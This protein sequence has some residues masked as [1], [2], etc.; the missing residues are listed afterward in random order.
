MERAG[1]VARREAPAHLRQQHRAGRNADDADRQLIDAIGVIDRRHRACG[2]QR[3]DDRIGEERDLEPRRANDGGSER[4]EEASHVRAPARAQRAPENARAP[5]VDD[6]QRELQRARGRDPPSGRVSRVR[7]QERKRERADHREIQEH[8][9]ESGGRE[10]PLRVERARQ[11]RDERDEREIRERHARERN[12][13]RELARLVFEAWG[14]QSD[15][16][17]RERPRER[18]ERELAHEQK[19]ADLREKA[20]RRRRATRLE[21]ARVGRH[22]SRVEGAF[23]EDRAEMIGQPERDIECVGERARA[24]RRAEHH[25]AHEPCRARHERQSRDGCELAVHVTCFGVDAQASG[26]GARPRRPARRRGR[27][28]AASPPRKCARYIRRGRR[29]TEAARRRET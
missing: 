6:K 17:R 4:G 2:Q 12:R 23:A 3:G 21:H 8:R 11:Q 15:E 28:G 18:Q 10:P 5:R 13:E 14:E 20:L 27:A 24:K 7:E 22:E 16:R 29:A 19:R 26:R 9:R 25:V 1:R